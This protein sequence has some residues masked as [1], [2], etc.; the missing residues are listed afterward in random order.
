MGYIGYS[1]SDLVSITA[2]AGMSRSS[3]LA[4]RQYRHRIP[5]VH[6]VLCSSR[7]SGLVLP[8]KI[9]ST[10]SNNYSPSLDGCGEVVL[11]EPKG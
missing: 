5:E 6:P 2:K 8:S 7:L 3:S 1:L 10:A 4:Q 9:S 11:D